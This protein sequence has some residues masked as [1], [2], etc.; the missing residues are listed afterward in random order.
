MKK[1]TE[2]KFE[3]KYDFETE[4]KDFVKAKDLTLGAVYKVTGLYKNT[5]G[6]YGEHWIAV[7]ED[8]LLSLSSTLN[9]TMKRLDSD[10]DWVRSVN[11]GRATVFTTERQSKKYGS[12]YYPIFEYF[13]EE[14]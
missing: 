14:M 3:K 1:T 13:G 6:Q 12:Y 2:I 10:S 11:E 7:L 8:A 9:D 5:K 4:G